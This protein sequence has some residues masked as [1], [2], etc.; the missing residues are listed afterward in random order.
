MSAATVNPQV[1]LLEVDE[2]RAERDR[3]R[4]E[5]ATAKKDIKRLLAERKQ[6]TAGLRR[7]YGQARGETP[8]PSK[9]EGE[10]E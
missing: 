2:L 6:L 4:V 10:T 9:P 3:M 1:Y 7:L 5:L 8:F